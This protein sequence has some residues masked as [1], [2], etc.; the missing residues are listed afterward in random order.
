MLESPSLMDCLALE[1][2]YTTGLSDGT[3]GFLALE[4]E[5]SKS[6]TYYDNSFPPSFQRAWQNIDSII[7]RQPKATWR[8]NGRAD[9]FSVYKEAQQDR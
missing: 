9:G 8:I 2:R 4:D 1:G 3:Q 5:H 7:Q 6:F